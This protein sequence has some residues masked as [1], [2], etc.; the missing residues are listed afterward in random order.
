[1]TACRRTVVL[2]AL[3]AGLMLTA[4]CQ[5]DGKAQPL[6]PAGSSSTTAA[7]P[8]S[9]LPDPTETTQPAWQAKYSEKE[10]AAYEEALD[11]FTTYEQ[12]S[13]P[14]WRRGKATP[15]AEELFKEYFYTW[16]DQLRRLQTY[17]QVN[18]KITGVPSALNSRP[19]RIK[20]ASDGQSVTIR[21]CVDFT[22]SVV[23]QDGEPAPGASKVP[24]IRNIY[25]SRSTKPA[26]TPWR[27]TATNVTKQRCSK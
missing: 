5:G 20:I 17:E 9:S 25:L 10:I 22:T 18:V 2:A 24:L 3:C 27:I 23:T 14:I 8:S 15:A 19:T 4:G 11:R 16:Q 6:P 26:A 13:E 7:E 1:M 12:G 21:Q